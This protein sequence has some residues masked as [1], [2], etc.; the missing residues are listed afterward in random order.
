MA[1]WT[2]VLVIF[3]DACNFSVGK[4]MINQ[5]NGLMVFTIHLWQ[6]WRWFTSSLL[7]LMDFGDFRGILGCLR[8]LWRFFV[9]FLELVLGMMWGI[10]DMCFRHRAL[11]GIFAGFSGILGRCS[12][13][14]ERFWSNR[15]S[16]TKESCDLQ[17]DTLIQLAVTSKKS[18]FRLDDTMDAK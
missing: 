10:F 18:R 13:N 2:N 8:V 17:L 14:D 9:G 11:L 15:R 6:N 7:T 16:F 3:D 12:S 5:P 4:A 1:L